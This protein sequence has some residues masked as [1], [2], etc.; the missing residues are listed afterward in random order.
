MRP[1]HRSVFLC[2]ALVL[3]SGVLSKAQK[4]ASAQNTA[5]KPLI[6]E[7]VDESQ[8]VTLRGNTPPVALGQND[9]GRVSAGMSMPGL[10]LVLRRSPEQQAAFDAFVASQYDATSANYHHWLEPE[11]VGEKF[12]PAL[13]DIATVSSW[14]SSH[15]F[16]VD[17]V[18]KDRMTIRFSGSAAQ[19]EEAFHTELHNLMV[20]GEPHIS[21]M[22][23]PQIPMALEPVVL[24]PKALHNFIPKPMHRL[25]GK[26]TLNK[27]TGSWQPIAK[28]NDATNRL[29]PDMGFGCGANCQLEDVTPFDFATIYNVLPQ[30][31]AT[32]PIDGTGQTIAIAGRS[33]VR[34]TDVATFRST[35]GLP[36][37]T[38]NLIMNGTD[39]GFCT[40]NTG[41][42]TLDDQIENALDVEWSGA[43]AKGA[44]VDL[45]VTQQTNSNDAIFDSASY[46]INNK[47][48]PIINVSYG[49]CELGLGTAGNS[50]Y[51]TLWQTA[52]T[53]GIAVFAATGDSGSPSCD[54]GGDS[55][56]TP[57]S[58]KY[59]L[60]VSG[61]ASSV[62]DTAVGGTDLN[63]GTTAAPYWNATNNGTNGSTAKG[64]MP[65]TPWND[66]CTNPLALTY[67]Q[68]IATYLNNH[69][70]SAPNPTNAESSCNFIVN[71]WS[72][73]NT[74]TG[75]DISSF[76]DTVGGG[77]GNSNCTTSDGATVASCTG[78]YPKP[79]WQAGVTGF[80]TADS[81][82]DIPDVSFFAGNGFLGSAYLICVSDWGACVTSPTIT[83]EPTVGEVGGTSAASPAMAGV[84]ALINQKAASAQGS[85]NTE[86]Y[87]L[88]GKQT[89]AGCTTESGTVSNGCYFND[90]DTGTIAMPCA[91]ASPN[92]TVSKSGDTVGVLSGINAGVGY[93][94]ATGLGSLNV[95]NVVNAF[96]AT[97]AGTA[98]ATVAATATPS[99][100]NV[101]Q[102]TNVT[103]TVSGTSGTPTG[104]VSLSGGGY[105]SGSSTLVNGSY[106]IAI[107]TGKLNVGAD[108]L[109]VGY[110]GDTTYAAA[111][112]T[113]TVTVTK[114][115]TAVTVVPAQSAIVSN[116]SLTVTGTV[117]GS[118][119]T[120]TGTVT[121]S[122]GGYTSSA[123]A[124]TGG[125]YS[126]TIPA[127]SLSG[128][129]DTLTA[130]YSGDSVY[131]AST[132]T[133]VVTVTTFVPL[134]PKV[135]VT[136]AATSIDTG[137]TLSVAVAVTGSGAMPTGSVTISQG[138]YTS[139]AQSL[140][141]GA[142]TFDIPAN[143]LSAGTD[144]LTVN[145][146][147]D[148]N[149][150]AGSGTA[151]VT[152][153]ASA[154]TLAATTPANISRGSQAAS[155]I[156]WSTTTNYSGTVTL[157]GCTLNS[158]APANSAADT[159]TCTI[160][161][162]AI[163]TSGSGT[164]TVTTKAATT[165]SLTRPAFPQR[166]IA[167]AGSGAIL[168]LTVFF[169][170]PARRRSWRVM[171]GMLL[172]M[173]TL[174]SIAACG[175]GSGSS[176]G[177][178]GT[179][180]AGTA[181]GQYVFTVTGAGNPVVTPAP[182]TTFTVT[183][184]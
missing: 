5:S 118:G 138:G 19:V 8:L 68:S 53:Q 88:A 23:D 164:A 160:S 55:A 67:F 52:S 26:A 63:W 159:P 99:S 175:G 83:V 37:G 34:A 31:N 151:S 58:A 142:Y 94:E 174:G 134:T 129:A 158:G 97:T 70:V 177:G 36:A 96:S 91:S 7:R 126:I 122:G 120:P 38:F 136:P 182:T 115:T 119:G 11:E 92:C 171:L 43:V 161:S 143:T 98:T 80:P 51:N 6:V 117:S 17:A 124:I 103:V 13:A 78:G 27:E 65:E 100:I 41:N 64:Y 178:G 114:V 132:K 108:T 14:L 44:I 39:P 130:S 75:Q 81:K 116:V 56:G 1:L 152:V 155:T 30:W 82:R 167:L 22:S 148:V 49:L 131:L 47:I 109:T 105:A 137:Q 40:G 113:V 95:S 35:F 48:A 153:T 154:Y 125:S 102:T 104:T 25:G 86:L 66:S 127:N 69:G 18:S 77:G 16:S 84:M 172:L 133:A 71:Y 33:D 150:A 179:H 76:V 89:Y 111:S 162:S 166:G 128:G 112:G 146:D 42:C 12:G 106:T 110:S 156:S 173:M 15:G 168:A 32:S 90:I 165:S 183:V 101:N 4:T 140:A 169:G 145:Y 121:L 181:S 163:A 29:R 9:R 85:P 20:K 2:L 157:S 184:N 50:S 123:T 139:S 10:I 147:G 45:V 57:Y 93:D 73:F 24:G 3:V 79:S 61:I 170:I 59:G 72:S 107:P 180:D 62:F 60:S 141:A 21:N 54:Q 144:T 135:T 28:Q 46:I 87:L 149:Y 176:G 74:L